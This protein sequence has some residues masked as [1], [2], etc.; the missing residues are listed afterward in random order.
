MK[1][2]KEKLETYHKSKGNCLLIQSIIK[3]SLILFLSCTLFGCVSMV[4]YEQEYSGSPKPL[5]QIAIVTQRWPALSGTRI[6]KING[7]AKDIILSQLI[8][9][10]AG[11]HRL[12][13][14][15]E[16]TNIRSTGDLTIALDAEPGH[17]YVLYTVKYAHKPEWYPAI[18]D[19]TSELSNPH[20]KSFV[21]KIDAILKKNRPAEILPS[22]AT[23]ATT[24]STGP[25]A[26]LGNFWSGVR[27]KMH[28]NIK[29][30]VGENM[31][32]TYSFFRYEP[33]T[34]AFG[35]NSKG[36]LAKDSKGEPYI[37]YIQLNPV[38]GSIINVL[39]RSIWV[40]EAQMSGFQPLNSDFVFVYEYGRH[41]RWITYRQAADGTFSMV[42]K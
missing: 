11:Q 3:W 42:P 16:S 22:I 17:V 14:C 4:R 9:L 24:E 41:D 40:E 31:D 19:I 7:K 20:Y 13:V 25:I 23:L 8:E 10:P 35:R 32:V 38:D 27:K 5:Q 30:W 1:K 29:I 39:G 2:E 34:T 18:W 33:F 21:N 28:G 37:F 12:D 26:G 6:S 36:A 15:F